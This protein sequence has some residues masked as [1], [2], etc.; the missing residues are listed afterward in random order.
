MSSYKTLIINN[1]NK[2]KKME[3]PKSISALLSIDGYKAVTVLSLVVVGIYTAF[4]LVDKLCGT[5]VVI[6]AEAKPNGK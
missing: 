5:S 4:K 3:N 6:N 1:K 2:V